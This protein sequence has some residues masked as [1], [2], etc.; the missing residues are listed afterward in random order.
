MRTPGVPDQIGLL[1]AKTPHRLLDFTDDHDISKVLHPCTH[2]RQEAASPGL[3]NPC[4]APQIAPEEE[5]IQNLL[6]QAGRV[7]NLEGLFPAHFSPGQGE[8][9][10]PPITGGSTQTAGL[11]YYTSSGG[12]PDSSKDNQHI[13][14]SSSAQM[15]TTPSFYNP[16]DPTIQQQ[17]ENQRQYQ[18]WI[19]DNYTGQQPSQQVPYQQSYRPV[20]ITS[21]FNQDAQGQNPYAIMQEQYMPPSS[22]MSQYGGSTSGTVTQ[23]ALDGITDSTTY[24]THSGD[25]Y[26][27]YPNLLPVTN[28]PVSTPGG[29]TS[30]HTSTPESMT[31][32]HTNTP[33]PIYQQQQQHRQQ[34]HHQQPPQQQQAPAERFAQQANH[35]API[36]V[37][38]QVQQKPSNPALQG[39]RYAAHGLPARYI[40]PRNQPEPA[41]QQSFQPNPTEPR[42]STL[43]PAAKNWSNEGYQSQNPKSG[44]LPVHQFVPPPSNQAG[45]SRPKPTTAAPPKKPTATESTPNGSP[46]QDKGGVKRKRAK[47]N[48]SPDVSAFGGGEDSDTD[49]DDDDETGLGMSGRMT[50][51][52]GGLGVPAGRGKRNKGARL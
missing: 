10:A 35:Q 42:A 14:S 48:E 8:L 9:A 6:F 26:S 11:W 33:E 24:H 45:P 51:G 52:L 2:Q 15:I 20:P 32:S 7:A 3:Q 18:Q 17:R 23:C 22:S 30:Y 36:F 38:R 49:S 46:S 43:S 44:S 29:G 12:A 19:E 28:S 37:N 41:P 1:V 16:E 21:T 25:V 50:V 4:R 39:P 5:A 47:K 40:P 34:Q 31:N 27:F 13:A